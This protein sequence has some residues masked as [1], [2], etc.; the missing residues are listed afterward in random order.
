METNN[1]FQL[2]VQGAHTPVIPSAIVS[3]GIIPIPIYAVT[4]MTLTEAYQFPPIG[5][6]GA[7]AIL[8]VHDDSVTIKG[9]L[10]GDL[11]FT[12]KVALELLAESSKRGNTYINGLILITAMT[13]RTEMQIRTLTFDSLSTRRHTLDLT[14]VMD[15]MP[16]PKNTIGKLVD[17]LGSIAVGALGDAGGN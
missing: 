12:W 9:S 4:Q 16:K 14:L 8:Q 2:Y 11:R 17:A 1:S 7:K 13:V 6:S 3:D 5:S 10:V 15:Y